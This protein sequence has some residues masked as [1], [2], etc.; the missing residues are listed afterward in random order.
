MSNVVLARPTSFTS[1]VITCTK[2]GTT[3]T[4]FWI[5][6]LDCKIRGKQKMEITTGDGD[7]APSL[8]LNYHMLTSITMR[9]WLVAH[10]VNSSVVNFMA[11]FIDSAKN[12]LAASLKIN[13]ATSVVF[14]FAKVVI[15]EFE[16]GY[17]RD[18][19][20]LPL[21]L[22]CYQTDTHATMAAT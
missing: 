18:G 8:D 9:G 2:F 5:K 21:M 7:A 14:T 17:S 19:A 20:T 1:A 3:G 13:A 11:N 22:Q 12:P 16:F 15:P 6:L 4:D 10:S